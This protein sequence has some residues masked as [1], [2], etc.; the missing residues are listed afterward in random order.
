MGTG[1]S[2]FDP[3]SVAHRRQARRAAV[4]SRADYYP[5]ALD[6]LGISCVTFRYRKEKPAPACANAGCF[7]L[8]LA[9]QRTQEVEQVLLLPL[10]EVV[11]IP[12]HAVRFRA[13]A[14]MLLD[15]LQQV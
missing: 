12:D 5:S 9:L 2:S 4:Q 6:Q 3:D 7:L 13:I 15:R 10:G 11:E 14:R 8:V 1:R